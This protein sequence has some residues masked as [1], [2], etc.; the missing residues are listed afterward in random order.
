MWIV[1]WTINHGGNN[2]EDKWEAFED[3]QLA[4][5]FYRKQKKDED[6]Q[7]IAMSKLVIS[8]NLEL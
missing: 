6:T 7:S 8:D 1:A 3:D 5:H 2:I 4:L